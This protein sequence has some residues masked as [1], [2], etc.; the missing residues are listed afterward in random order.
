[1][2]LFSGHISLL[3]SRCPFQQPGYWGKRGNGKLPVLDFKNLPHCALK[4]WNQSI[5]NRVH[6]PPKPKLTNRPGPPRMWRLSLA[7]TSRTG[8]PGTS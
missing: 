5:A 3:F 1:M 6:L 8:S 2:A 7:F 4:R